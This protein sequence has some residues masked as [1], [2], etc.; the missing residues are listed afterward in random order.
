MFFN[1]TFFFVQKTFLRKYGT[2]VVT[3]LLLKIEVILK[4]NSVKEKS[5][6]ISFFLS[7]N[8]MITAKVVRVQS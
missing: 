8:V 6:I 2:F 1:V 5:V 3:L 7:L 4:Y